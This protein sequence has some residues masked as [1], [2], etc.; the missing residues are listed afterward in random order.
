[1][2]AYRE[3]GARRKRANGM[4]RGERGNGKQGEEKEGK[5][6]MER[7]KGETEALGRGGRNMRSAVRNGGRGGKGMLER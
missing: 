1:M 5:E 6:R 2:R 4:T 7:V 3:E